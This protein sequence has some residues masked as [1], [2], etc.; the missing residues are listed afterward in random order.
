M[1]D[2]FLKDL[3]TY[4]LERQPDLAA[5]RASLVWLVEY[6]EGSPATEEEHTI[7]SEYAWNHLAKLDNE[8]EEDSMNS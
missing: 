4:G 7:Y 1:L 8:I 5:L 3:A 6:Y 2:Q